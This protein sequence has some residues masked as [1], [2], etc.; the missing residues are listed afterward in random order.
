MKKL[1]KKILEENIELLSEKLKLK[2]FVR[3]A[4]ID[5]HVTDGST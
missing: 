1:N 5:L 4:A 2:I 3:P